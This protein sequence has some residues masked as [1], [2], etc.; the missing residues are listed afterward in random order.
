MV[1]LFV[2][3]YADG[4]P[5][6]LSRSDQGDVSIR[7]YDPRAVPRPIKDMVL[8]GDLRGALTQRVHAAERAALLW[9]EQPDAAL[10]KVQLELA[11]AVERVGRRWKRAIAVDVLAMVA[12]PWRELVDRWRQRPSARRCYWVEVHSQKNRKSAVRGQAAWVQTYGLSKIGQ[13]EVAVEF[14]DTPPARDE[15]LG[16]IDTLTETAITGPKG[17][18]AGETVTF[19]WSSLVLGTAPQD[20]KRFETP[21]YI[22][23]ALQR[24]YKPDPM[25]VV[26]ERVD[27]IEHE[28]A[29]GASR[30]IDIRLRQRAALREHEMDPDSPSPAFDATAV[31]CRKVKLPMRP[32]LLG[33]FSPLG[34]RD[35]GWVIR[36]MDDR[37]DHSNKGDFEVRDLAKLA[38]V[39]PEI[40]TYIAFPRG[41]TVLLREDGAVESWPPE[42]DEPQRSA[43]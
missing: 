27:D 18:R 40:L 20:H 37:H 33:R 9:A 14:V 5:L 34:G 7:E 16:V 23:H 42:A 6:A 17:L 43:G 11:D 41:A 21:K 38:H 35:S 12:S 39:D 24:F 26:H 8:H 30:A 32:V 25:L 36:C 3:L 29:P 22:R 31:V 15:A 1:R 2:V 19:G 13:P 4:S 28:Y 10:E